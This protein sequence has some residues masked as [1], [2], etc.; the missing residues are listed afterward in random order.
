MQ[1]ESAFS[2]SVFLSSDISRF[3]PAKALE[4]LETRER[5]AAFRNAVNNACITPEI[6]DFNPCSINDLR[7]IIRLAKKVHP[8]EMVDQLLKTS[9]SLDHK[10]NFYPDPQDR[11][12]IQRHTAIEALAAA[13]TTILAGEKLMVADNQISIAAV[14]PPGHHAGNETAGYCYLNN[15]VIALFRLKEINPKLRIAILDLDAHFGNGTAEISPFPYD[16]LGFNNIYMA[17]RPVTGKSEKVSFAKFSPGITEQEY[18][19]KL[20]EYLDKIAVLDLDILGLSLGFDT[21]PRDSAALI[22]LDQ[23]PITNFTPKTYF[24]I[25]MLIKSKIGRTKLLVCIEGGYNLTAIEED[26]HSFLW[27]LF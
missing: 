8:P 2:L 12:E 21:D 18:L 3:L 7:K 20:E 9:R 11:H 4:D 10:I 5:L 25:A 27:G 17:N 26:L 16:S 1:K 24:K 19:K 14:R 13:G 23:K 22:E 15:L 6:N